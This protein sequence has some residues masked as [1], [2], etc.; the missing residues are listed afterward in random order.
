MNYYRYLKP[1]IFKLN[2]EVAHNL[3]I[4]AAKYRLLPNADKANDDEHLLVNKL[5]Q[6]DFAHP[7][8]LAA[9]FDK[10][11]EAIDFLLKQDFAFVEMGTVTPKSQIG[12]PKPRLFR[13][14]EDEAIINA[15]GFNNYGL[16]VFS[17]NIAK[18]SHL[19]IMGSNIGKNKDSLESV[20]DYLLGLEKLYNLSDYITVNISSPNTPGLRNLQHKEELANLLKALLQKKL[21][22]IS[23]T[24]KK[25]PI[26]LKIAPDLVSKDLEDIIENVITYGI[27][28]VI[29]SNTTIKRDGL[30]SKYRDKPGGLS[31][32]PLFHQSTQLLREFYRLSNGKIPIIASGG[33]FS[34]E[35]AYQKIINGASLIQ[36]YTVLIYQGFEAV[37]KIKL[38]LIA[39]LK[40]EG[41]TLRTAIGINV[42]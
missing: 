26:L 14:E 34:G 9:G 27:D 40:S 31:G 33:I 3:A 20:E 28:G 24:G 37:Q 17:R 39:K 1:L 12:N 7:I 21:E 16:E 22:L 15:M 4:F 23:L 36:L 41:L 32:K 6:I 19:G 42:N 11:A 25:K 13:L 18:R 8:G 29:I 10:N 5:W 30:I 35:D 38:E 2:P